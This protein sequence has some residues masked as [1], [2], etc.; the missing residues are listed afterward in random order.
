MRRRDFL[1]VATLAAIPATLWLV[2]CDMPNYSTTPGTPSPAT[3]APKEIGEPLVKPADWKAP[4]TAAAAEVDPLVVQS[5][6]LVVDERQEVPSQ[7]DGKLEAICTEIPAGTDISTLDPA[8]VFEYPEPIDGVAVVGA[9]KYRYLKEGE[10]VKKGQ[11]VGLLDARRALADLAAGL[12]SVDA[13]KESYS[14]AGQITAAAKAIYDQEIKLRERGLGSE[15]DLIQAQAGWQQRRAEE[16]EKK[17]LHRK[18][19]EELK[20]ADVM[21]QLHEIRASIPGV[22]RTI[23]RKK[24]MSVKALE[25]VMEIH[26]ITKLRAEGLINGEDLHRVKKDMAVIVEPSAP[27]GPDRALIGHTQPVTG[28]AVSKNGLIVSASEDHS[29][30]VWT[31]REQKRILPHP[32]AVRAVACT[33]PGVAED[34]CL[35]GADDGKLRLWDLAGSE[36]KP[37]KTLEAHGGAVRCIAFAPA[38][39]IAA[40]ADDHVVILWDWQAGKELYRLPAE[41]RGPVTSLQ[42]TPH[43]RLVSAARDNTLLVWELGKLGARV[44]SAKGDDTAQ[45]R[46][47]KRS[48]DV[49]VLGVSRDGTR[50]LYDQGRG[51]HILG[52]PEPGKA[53]TDGLKTLGVLDNT[54]EMR[55]STFALFAPDARTILTGTTSEG[56]MQ[57]WRTP[58]D[59]ERPSELRQYVSP[60]RNA[61]PTCAAYAPDGKRVVTGSAD[62]RVFVW[63]VPAADAAR[64]AIPATI[65][66]VDPGADASGRQV[67]VW[68]EIPN[69]DGRLLPG[70]TVTLVVSDKSASR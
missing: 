41:H 54:S 16:A 18:A 23:Y 47:D 27:T 6:Q 37:V 19:S 3:A 4:A 29:A 20:K 61:A 12:A 26:N 28:V 2:G 52:L 7:V 59:G 39:T 55:F 63:P 43:G 42:F 53:D 22:V 15:R 14:A 38:G 50:V 31:V 25:P 1:L 10:I 21:V 5:A 24:G 35:T 13:A 30:R 56:K 36:P 70:S 32:V 65:T 62:G 46:L 48:G 9:K 51:L 40:T 33:P 67:R 11:L 66:F 44:E 68:A 45:L 64:D 58:A 69:K 8:T 34:Y 17:G 60:D 57:L 49:S